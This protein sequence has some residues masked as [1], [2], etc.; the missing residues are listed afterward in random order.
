MSLIARYRVYKCL[1]PSRKVAF[2]FK[3]AFGGLFK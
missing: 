3:V 1:R 2:A